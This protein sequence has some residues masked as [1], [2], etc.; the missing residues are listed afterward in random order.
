LSEEDNPLE[1]E[2]FSPLREGELASGAG[3]EVVV[4]TLA[5]VDPSLVA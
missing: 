1:L 2:L 3:V 5:I 4:T